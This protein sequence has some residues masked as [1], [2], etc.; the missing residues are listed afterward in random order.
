MRSNGLMTWDTVC[1]SAEKNRDAPRTLLHKDN[2]HL[3][4]VRFT[5]GRDITITA[6]PAFSVILVSRKSGVVF[7]TISF[8]GHTT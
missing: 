7:I 5:S 8:P 6:P 4:Y 2:P 3:E 1:S